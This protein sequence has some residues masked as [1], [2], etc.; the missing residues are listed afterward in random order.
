[1][2]GKRLNTVW[3]VVLGFVHHMEYSLAAQSVMLL[4]G[5]L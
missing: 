5:P 3:H 1:M 4:L 2:V